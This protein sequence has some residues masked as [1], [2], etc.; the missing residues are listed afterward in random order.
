MA[1]DRGRGRLHLLTGGNYGP[2]TSWEWNG[3][4]W[5]RLPI[6]GQP[7]GAYGASLTYDEHRRMLV[8]Y[9]FSGTVVN[10]LWECDGTRWMRR[11]PLHRPPSSGFHGAAYDPV[12]REMIVCTGGTAGGASDLMWSWNWDRWQQLTPASRPSPR[13]DATMIIDRRRQHVM[14]YGGMDP[15]AA[16][17]HDQWEWDGWTWRRLISSQSRTPRASGRAD[18]Y[19]QKRSRL[20][21][22]GGYSARF[23]PCS[24]V[25]AMDLHSG[26]T[27]LGTGDES[28][29]L[30]APLPALLGG[31]L[32]LRFPSPR[33]SAVLGLAFAA[34]ATAIPLR[35]PLFCSAGRLRVDA[36]TAT[37]LP[38]ASDPGLLR[39]PIPT[40]ASLIDLPLYSQALVQTSPNCLQATNGLVSLIRAR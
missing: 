13:S 35:P 31:E 33:Q 8:L 3:S 36:A 38:I 39:L 9:S 21:S 22:I 23:H 25:W 37:W 32:M 27:G 20:W 11:S 19:D 26:S 30:I 15:A 14:L 29:Q 17:L 7:I 10:E 24:E 40:S 5:L 16:A 4:D 2:S 34:P 12:R 1:F 6:V 28:M 18:A